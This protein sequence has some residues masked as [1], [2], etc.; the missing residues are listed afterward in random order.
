[1]NIIC[2]K[3]TKVITQRLSYNVQQGDKRCKHVHMQAQTKML[4]CKEWHYI[5][6]IICISRPAVNIG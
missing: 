5:E 2:T 1:M 6:I 4:L 3:S